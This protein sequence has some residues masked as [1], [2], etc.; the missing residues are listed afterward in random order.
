MLEEIVKIGI[1]IFGSSALF[2]FLQFL[3]TRKDKKKDKLNE[4]CNKLDEEI[5]SQKDLVEENYA[6]LHTEIKDGLQEREDTG[7]K[8]YEEHQQSIKLLNEA[9]LQLTKNDNEQSKYMKYIGEEL[10]GLAHEKL[11]TLTDHYQT[12]GAITL[13]EK[14]TLESIYRP[15]HEGLGGNGDGT[16]GYNF[17]MKLP[18]VTDMQAI[19]MDKKLK[20]ELNL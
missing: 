8:R 4:L 6:A 2:T 11:V 9:S 5:K 12:R 3:I 15:Y 1:A 14:A 17:C 7:R 10:M 13:R 19:D 16:Q 20:N 18:V